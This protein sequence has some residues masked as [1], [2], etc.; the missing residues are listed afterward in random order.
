MPKLAAKLSGGVNTLA[1]VPA[2]QPAVIIT[3]PLSVNS[4]EALIIA[5][6]AIKEAAPGAYTIRLTGDF[7]CNDLFDLEGFE[8][9]VITL[10]GDSRM[11]TITSFAV[12]GLFDIYEEA[13]LVLGNNVT[14]NGNSIVYYIVSVYEGGQLEMKN[15]AVITN[16][17]NGG[18]Y[19]NG[20]FNMSGGTISNNIV[21]YEGGG[22]WVHGGI[23]NMSGGTITNN[24]SGDLVG[25]GGVKITN[26]L[27]EMSGGTI[28]NNTASNNTANG[29]GGGVYLSNDSLFN[30]SGGTITNN[31]AE[32]G[33]G[34]YIRNST[35]TMR[36]GT[37]SGNTAKGW[38]GGVCVSG[39]FIKTGGTIDATNKAAEGAV[40]Y[41]YE[42]SR[43]TQS[44]P[45]DSV[46]FRD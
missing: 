28:S 19:V 16:S 17:G 2:A 4:E 41:A 24:N 33:G 20:T 8:K 30:M 43:E 34:V 32:Y 39:T 35:F 9:K 10:Q 1:E 5:L 36:G 37:I 7:T 14:L 45:S 23:F 21:K 6:D 29:S 11:R 3:G 15:G 44:G 18:V 46:T 26:G 40:W 13:V 25:G 42:N 38:G 12:G 31:T 27:F 22:V